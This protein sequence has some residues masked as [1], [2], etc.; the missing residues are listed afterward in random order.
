MPGKA[1]AQSAVWVLPIDLY[2]LFN[3]ATDFLLIWA[4]GAWTGEP[5]RPWRALSAAALG[6]L[7][8]A[9]TVWPGL[10]RL[11]HPA[12]WLGVG[13]AMVALAYG[14]SGW[15]RYLKL[16]GVFYLAYLASAGAAFAFWL[17]IPSRGL[18]AD[19]P[20]WLDSRNLVPVAIL[21]VTT[22]GRLL[23]PAVMQWWERRRRTV[24]LRLRIGDREARVRALVDTGNHLREPLSGRPVVIAWYRALG[25]ALPAEVELLYRDGADPPAAEAIARCEAGSLADQV[26]I[27]P[28]RSLGRDGG[29]LFGLR[30]EARPC[31]RRDAGRV[32]VVAV[33]ARPVDPEGAY[34]AICPPELAS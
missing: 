4:A 2:F 5:V 33:V 8:A 32:A 12:L 6:G 3:V 1:G 29:M 28:F 24:D 26:T 25:Q 11:A 17:S 18:F 30:A 10:G 22:L 14:I 34:Q 13:A 21:L 27:V 7:Y 20:P 31:D 15:R 16:V 9:A 19:A 23:V